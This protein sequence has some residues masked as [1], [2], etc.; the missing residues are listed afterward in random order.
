MGVRFAFLLALLMPHASS[1]A[2]PPP[3]KTRTTCTATLCF[4]ISPVPAVI[5]SQH[6]PGTGRVTTTVQAAPGVVLVIVSKLAQRLT[7][8]PLTPKFQWR[9]RSDL[10]AVAGA[11]LKCG[12][13]GP[14]PRQWVGLAISARSPADMHSYLSTATVS[15]GHSSSTGSTQRPA[16]LSGFRN[17]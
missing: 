17:P 13:A 4:D 9:K 1:V 5:S 6:T 7:G 8:Q 12:E 11:C 15:S 10:L 14:W 2:T 3:E 16:Q